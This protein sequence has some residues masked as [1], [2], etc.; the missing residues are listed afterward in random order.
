MR[1][2]VWGRR[3]DVLTRGRRPGEGWRPGSQQQIRRLDNFNKVDDEYMTIWIYMVH[4][5]RFIYDI[6]MTA[7]LTHLYIWMKHNDLMWWRHWNDGSWRE[8]CTKGLVSAISG[9]W[10]EFWYLYLAWPKGGWYR[11]CTDLGRLSSILDSPFTGIY[12]THNHLLF[13]MA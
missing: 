8:L 3:K 9:W 5:W 10:T 4:V 13:T 11:W 7:W 12:I 6:Y 2:R 1:W